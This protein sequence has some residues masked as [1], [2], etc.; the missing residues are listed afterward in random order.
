MVG[1]VELTAALVGTGAV[2]W[3]GDVVACVAL[4]GSGGLGV[5]T[6]RVE[7][8][9]VGSVLWRGDVAVRTWFGDSWGRW[10]W[11]LLSCGGPGMVRRSWEHR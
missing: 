2:L 5:G 7:L 11:F 1:G 4:W 9:G 6:A 10:G 8:V 3:C